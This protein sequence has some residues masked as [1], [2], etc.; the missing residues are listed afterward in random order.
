MSW[1]CVWRWLKDGGQ[2][3]K[4]KPLIISAHLDTV[5]PLDMDLKVRRENGKVYG[6]GI[7][8]NSIGVAALVGLIWM[9][10][11]QRFAPLSHRSEREW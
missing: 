7:G 6:I 3:I 2:S 11:E 9:L 1:E 4:V 5:F 8:D 10:K